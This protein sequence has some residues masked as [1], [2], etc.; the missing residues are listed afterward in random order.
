MTY[1][2]G[3]DPGG[4]TGYAFGHF[5]DDLPFMLVDAY[6]LNPVQVH[7]ELACWPIRTG[8]IHVVEDFRLRA[9]NEFT[10]DLQGDRLIGSMEFAQYLGMNDVP[11]VWQMPSEKKHVTDQVLKD[12]GLW[13]T[14]KR[15][16]A[17]S[18]RH[19]NDA[20]VHILRYL[21]VELE[22]EPTIRH[23]WGGP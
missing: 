7:Q 5:T 22:H 8:W 12:A 13:F 2:D 9:S 19:I 10:A 11:L 6:T 20:I 1:I 21:K 3:Y 15:A 16:G 23:Y 17:K 18:G 4:A 14:P